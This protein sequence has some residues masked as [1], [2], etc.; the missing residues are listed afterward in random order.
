MQQQDGF[1]ATPGKELRIHEARS[2]RQN[3]S[4]AVRLD[5]A[6]LVYTRAKS[7]STT[8]GPATDIPLDCLE[9]KLRM[10]REQNESRKM[11]DHIR[12]PLERTYA[13]STSFEASTGT[14]L[15]KAVLRQATRQVRRLT[16]W[17]L[18]R[19]DGCYIQEVGLTPNNVGLRKGSFDEDT[20]IRF[21]SG[22]RCGVCF[23]LRRFGYVS[24]G[25]GS[26]Q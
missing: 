26:E 1:P 24:L 5:I 18:D 7:F 16:V 13:S 6:H 25:G 20:R 14:S 17:A 22:C 19:S 21:R 4:T 10:L 11:Q 23:H 2:E 12:S 15:L 3:L 8:T 9:P